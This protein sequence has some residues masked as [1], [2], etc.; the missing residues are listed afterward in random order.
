MVQGW[1]FRW[2]HP[3]WMAALLVPLLWCGLSLAEEP[4]QTV[5]IDQEV[6]FEPSV[7]IYLKEGQQV[8]EYSVNGQVYKVKIT[9]SVG[10]EYYL[11]D[12]DGDGKLESRHDDLK[13][14]PPTPQWVLV[15]W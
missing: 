10:P 3:L 1:G 11:I 14:N 15:R 6:P 4:E 13:S 9:P 7:R 2:I 8:E 5:N 12:L